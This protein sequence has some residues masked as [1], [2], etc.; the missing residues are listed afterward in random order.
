M[1]AIKEE[2]GLVIVSEKSRWLLEDED[3]TVLGNYA[4]E[5]GAIAAKT[6]WIEFALKRHP[7]K[8]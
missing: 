6:W 1:T 5:R 7:N 3:G 2:F 4:S 8:G